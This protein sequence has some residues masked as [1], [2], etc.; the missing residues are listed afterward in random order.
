M[1]KVAMER[2]RCYPDSKI[3]TG[4]YQQHYVSETQQIMEM[5]EVLSSQYFMKKLIDS[6]VTY[7][8]IRGVVVKATYN[9]RLI[10]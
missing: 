10:K 3:Q 9:T 6:A 5:G 1:M 2:G 4:P 8:G 7:K